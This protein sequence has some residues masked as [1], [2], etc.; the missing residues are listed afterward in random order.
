MTK[1]EGLADKK[2]ERGQAPPLQIN[3]E[4]RN[5]VALFYSRS[6]MVEAP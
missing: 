1:K 4:E 6:S 3:V 2:R 5:R